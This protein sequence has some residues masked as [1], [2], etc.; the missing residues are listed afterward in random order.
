VDY[1]K[2]IKKTLH[3]LDMVVPNL[4]IDGPYVPWSPNPDE[5][6]ANHKRMLEFIKFADIIGAKTIRVDFCSWGMEGDP[7]QE[8]LD[9]IIKRYREYAEICHDLGMKIGPENHFGWDNIPKNLKIVKDG[10]DHPAYGHLFHFTNFQNEPELGREI[11]MSYV[12]HTHVPPPTIMTGVA[13]D[14]MRELLKAGYDGYWGVE[15]GSTIHGY[16]RV[17]WHLACIN[18]ILAE[19]EEELYGSGKVVDFLTDLLK[20]RERKM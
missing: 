19:L 6:E 3:E 15:I 17:A 8:A 9:T 13:K 16:E 4:C 2:K 14:H 18:I 11:A 12:M 5:A 10:V 20:P 7:T 1:A